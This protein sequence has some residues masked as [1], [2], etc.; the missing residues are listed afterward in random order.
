VAEA[1]LKKAGERRGPTN[2][3]H[4]LTLAATRVLWFYTAG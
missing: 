4:S 3:L 1:L 2:N